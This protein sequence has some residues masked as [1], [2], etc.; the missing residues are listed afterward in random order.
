MPAFVLVNIPCPLNAVTDP[1]LTV[2]RSANV[3][4]CDHIP[5]LDA[6]TLAAV[7]TT[8]WALL[9]TRMPCPL[10]LVTVPTLI[11]TLDPLSALSPLAQIPSFSPDTEPDDS[12]KIAPLPLLN[13][14][15]PNLLL[16]V[17]EET[18]MR[19][20]ALPSFSA[21]TPES[22]PKTVAAEITMPVPPDPRNMLMPSFVP[23]T[24]PV[25]VTEIDRC[26]Y[27]SCT[28][29]PCPA[30]PVT[31]AAEMTMLPTPELSRL[32][33]TIPIVPPETDDASTLMSP[34]C[35]AN[36]SLA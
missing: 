14:Y 21:F 15:I 26:P 22:P 34:L 31:E 12:M 13:A 1:T 16:P 29:T 11:V 7:T 18:E 3:S 35:L 9:N 36:R 23:D 20:A 5:W 25:A 33:A 4:T 30:S 2:F 32:C 27:F 24:L 17:A 19:I 6:V 28:Q 10:E 8:S